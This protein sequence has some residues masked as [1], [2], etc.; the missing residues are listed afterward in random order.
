[1]TEKLGLSVDYYPLKFEDRKYAGVYAGNMYLEP[2]GPFSNFQYASNKFKAIFFGLNCESEKSIATLAED[3]TSRNIPIKQTSTVQIVDTS[4]IRQN[5]YL[6]IASVGGSHVKR[7]D[8]LRAEMSRRNENGLGI[9]SIKEISVGYTEGT[10]LLKWKKLIEPSE[11]LPEG[12]WKVNDSQSVRFVK[13]SICEV[14]GIVFKVKSLKKSKAWLKENNLI[15]VVHKDEI[16]MDKLKTY[17]LSIL[18]SE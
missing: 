8:S 2:C 3:L 11:I 17:G 5:I 13:S 1:M 16:E 4:F 15:G 7:E 18:L 9:E 6:N 10:A 12:I 14:I